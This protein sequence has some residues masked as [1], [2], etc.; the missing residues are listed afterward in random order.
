MSQASRAEALEAAAQ[1]GKT[2]PVAGRQAAPAEFRT[3]YSS[4]P[5][6]LVLL[7][8]VNQMF[9]QQRY[10]DTPH[11]SA[12]LQDYLS[13]FAV[14]EG[15]NIRRGEETTSC[16][17]LLR[18]SV[19]PRPDS[20]LLYQN[21]IAMLEVFLRAGVPTPPFRVVQRTELSAIQENLEDPNQ[22]PK[23]PVLLKH[24]YAASSRGLTQCDH[25]PHACLAAWFAQHPDQDLV[26][27]QQKLYFQRELRITYIGGQIVHGYWRIKEHVEDLAAST[28]ISNSTLSFDDLPYRQLQP[29]VELMS[30]KVMDVG[31]MDVV[32]LGEQEVRLVVTCAL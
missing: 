4:R 18:I 32:L 2:P 19:F 11:L 27:V 10:A 26:I 20:T 13:N 16:G 6:H 3:P 8:R 23:F 21:K 1:G 9:Q 14:C 25:G 12:A 22:W 30:Q 17:D 15:P 31:A 28:H 29:L 5:T 24:A 7:W